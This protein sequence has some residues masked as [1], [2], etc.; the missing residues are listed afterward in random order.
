M[1]GQT[2]AVDMYRLRRRGIM[3]ERIIGFKLDIA[4][5]AVNL[6]NAS[7]ASMTTSQILDP[8]AP[9]SRASKLPQPTPAIATRLAQR[10]HL[11]DA[12]AADVAQNGKATDTA[13]VKAV[14]DS[15][16]SL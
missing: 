4:N 1:L 12:A 10:A 8:F 2:R 15:I 16:S 6:N 11:G 13:G 3:E 9:P 7:L 14:L 5:A